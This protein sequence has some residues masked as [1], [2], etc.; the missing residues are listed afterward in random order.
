MKSFIF[1]PSCGS[2]DIIFD[3]IKQFKCKTCSFT[4]FQNVATAAAA[5][6]EYNNKILF[7]RRVREPGKGKLDL[8]GGFIDP[9]ESVEAGLNRELKEE[10]G[11]TLSEMKYLGSA[12][13]VYKSENI[14]YNTCDLFFFAKIDFLPSEFDISEIASLELLDPLIMKKDELAFNSTKKG[15]EIYVKSLT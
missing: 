14:T 4:Y 12:P 5:I 2:K 1:C 3:G 11:I 7:V 6:L 13:N 9:D 8:P 10:L 15:I